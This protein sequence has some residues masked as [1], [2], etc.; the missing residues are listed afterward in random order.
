MT[1]DFHAFVAAAGARLG[2][3]PTHWL[4]YRGDLRGRV[5]PPR[6]YFV[7][8]LGE[9]LYP[10]ETVYDPDESNLTRVGFATTKALMDGGLQE[11]LR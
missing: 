1:E 11:Q 9:L 2:V 5:T 10:I 4:N 8:G 7:S 3:E 6:G